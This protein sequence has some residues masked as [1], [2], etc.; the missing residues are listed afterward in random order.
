MAVFR[1]R[2]AA[3]G[4]TLRGG[5]TLQSGA[6]IGAQSVVPALAESLVVAFDPAVSGG[7][8]TVSPGLASQDI[9]AFAPTV[10]GAAT[11]SPAVA[12]SLVVAFSPTVGASF[13]IG[14][15]LAEQLVVVFDP[16]LTTG[17]AITPKTATQLVTVFNP[18][19]ATP[20]TDVPVPPLPR[21]QWGRVYRLGDR[22]R[23]AEGSARSKAIGFRDWEKVSP[24]VLFAAGEQTSIEL[25]VW[26]T[27]QANT[28]ND[29]DLL[30]SK[31]SAVLTAAGYTVTD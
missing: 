23:F 26:A 8:V 24:R 9:V 5:D 16:T 17:A 13:D 28:S 18:T 22:Y 12:E 29:A 15:A 4:S 3:G 31:V 20:Y 7:T 10:Y 27:L 25:L 1:L 21:T 6:V 19:V 2:Q 30:K 11:V 14:P